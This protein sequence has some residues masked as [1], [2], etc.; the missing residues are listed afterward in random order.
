MTI[1]E[2][3]NM[4]V[5]LAITL[6]ELQS[7]QALNAAWIKKTTMSTMASARLATAGAGS[8][9]GFQETKTR[10]PPTRR[11]PPKPLKKYPRICFV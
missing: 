11:M 5:I 3:G 4:V 7:C 10:I 2:S 8:P 6:L 1:Q 9:R